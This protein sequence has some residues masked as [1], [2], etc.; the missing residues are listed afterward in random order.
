MKEH[1]NFLSTGSVELGN[2]RSQITLSK[3]HSL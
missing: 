3:V 2:F 1:L